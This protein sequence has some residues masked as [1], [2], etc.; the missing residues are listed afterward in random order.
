MLMVIYFIIYQSIQNKY[1]ICIQKVGVILLMVGLIVVIHQCN[2]FSLQILNFHFL[3]RL[4]CRSVLWNFHFRLL[5][6][7]S[8]DAP[9]K[10]CD[11][12]QMN[13][14]RLKI[15]VSVKNRLSRG[16]VKN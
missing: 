11:I 9:A 1:F 14:L 6:H 16:V 7:S 3:S 15:D 4:H 5:W 10:S 12:H 2:E 8:P 13:P